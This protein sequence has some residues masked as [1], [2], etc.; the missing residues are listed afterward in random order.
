VIAM[1]NSCVCRAAF[2]SKSLTVNDV[3]FRYQIW[4]TAGQEKVCSLF[5][6]EIGL[7]LGS[8]LGLGLEMVSFS[9]W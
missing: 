4:D 6:F 9:L 2:F 8:G 7:G 5:L 3:T 1:K